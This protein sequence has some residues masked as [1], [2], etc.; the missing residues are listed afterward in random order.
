MGQPHKHAALIKAWAD[1]PQLE[2]QFRGHGCQSNCWYNMSPSA[3]DWS[4]SEVRIK[5]KTIKYRN[6]LWEPQ[7][8]LT[9]G[10]KIVCVCSEQE[11][12]YEPREK[13]QGFVKWLGDWQ[14]VVVE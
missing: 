4:V 11:H 2:L 8:S 10:K 3:P 7:C 13:W 5:P 1:N 12:Q 9:P 6:F 14:E